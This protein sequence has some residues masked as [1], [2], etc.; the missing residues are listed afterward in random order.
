MLASKTYSVNIFHEAQCILNS[1]AITMSEHIIKRKIYFFC[2][3][4]MLT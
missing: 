3:K 4:K 1:T 2:K